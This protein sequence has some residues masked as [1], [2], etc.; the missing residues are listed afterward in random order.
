MT[1]DGIKVDPGESE[2]QL[3]LIGENFANSVVE[4]IVDEY[5]AFRLAAFIDMG[6]D[7]QDSNPGRPIVPQELDSFFKEMCFKAQ[8]RLLSVLLKAYI[9]TLFVP[10]SHIPTTVSGTID[11]KILI[12]EL[13]CVKGLETTF[14]LEEWGPSFLGRLPQ[15]KS[16]LEMEAAFQEVFHI[17]GRLTTMD[18]FFQ[19]G[20]DS[21][22]AISLITAA[23]SR[24]YSLSI[25][26][27]YQN[28]RLGDLANVATPCPKSLLENKTHP[29]SKNADDSKH[30]HL[31]AAQ[32]AI[33]RRTRL[34][35]YTLH[36]L[37]KKA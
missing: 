22:A 35:T 17:V 32:R 2:R 34:K 18:H 20:G 10:I 3:H 13:D 25:G 28:P 9:P 5:G 8:Q 33:Y 16:E 24:T 31:E 36:Q 30:L 7:K 37:F 21:F 26:Q 12:N 23:R 29:Q 15:T 14:G 27:I 6:F 11:R 4:H 1:I 19:L